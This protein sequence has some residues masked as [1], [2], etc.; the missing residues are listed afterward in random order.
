[1]TTLKWMSHWLKPSWYDTYMPYVLLHSVG[2]ALPST[3]NS[4]GSPTACPLPEPCRSNAKQIMLASLGLGSPTPSPRP[5]TRP[6]S[7]QDQ[8]AERD[9]LPPSRTHPMCT[10]LHMY[11]Q[12]PC[13]PAH[14]C[15]GAPPTHA[16]TPSNQSRVW[17]RLGTTYLG[18][19]L[20]R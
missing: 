3:T 14:V 5:G 2:M 6:W 12:V 18:A 16:W 20:Y 10:G 19:V 8:A 17:K 1:M 13:P 15:M 11:A 4:E 9:L 7:W